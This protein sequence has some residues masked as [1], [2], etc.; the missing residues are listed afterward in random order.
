[1]AG[2]VHAVSHHEVP[3]CKPIISGELDG[4]TPRIRQNN[5]TMTPSHH[6]SK[7]LE[8]AFVTAQR[9]TRPNLVV[10]E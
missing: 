4:F 9:Q 1:M 10:V 2:F 8:T 3:L 7:T 6:Q 5:V